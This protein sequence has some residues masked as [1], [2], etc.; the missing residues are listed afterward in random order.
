[1]IT[2]PAPLVSVIVPTYNRAQMLVEAVSSVLQQSYGNIELIVVDDGSTDETKS[3]LAPHRER[4][5]Y[6]YQENRGPSAARNAG[7]SLA[8]GS[9]IAFLDS[10]DL[11]EPEKLEVQVGYLRDFPETRICQTE[12]IWIR[13]GIRVNPKRKHR[14]Y[15]GW[16]FDKMLPLCI[17]SPSAVLLEKNLLLEVGLF[18]EALPACED[19]DLWLRIGAFYQIALIDKA[20]VIKRGGHDG[21]QSRR[22]WGMD[23]FRVQSL[24]KLLRDFRL[25]AHHRE[26]VRQ[27]LIKKCRV[28][29]EGCEKHGRAKLH[30]YYTELLARFE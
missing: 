24:L 13:R 4:I 6:V 11:W 30:R 10:D 8:T 16:I 21:Q 20:L 15:S 9:L 12:E 5:R 7:I 25:S 14:K 3:A 1:M 22:F 29:A 23:R 17:V 18:D 19:Y 26:L 27:E 28:L 2:P